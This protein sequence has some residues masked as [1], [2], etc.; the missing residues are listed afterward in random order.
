M[1]GYNIGA[2]VEDRAIPI[3][4]EPER[5]SSGIQHGAVSHVGP[6]IYEHMLVPKMR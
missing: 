5:H 4:R 1:Y 3:H 2:T 6:P